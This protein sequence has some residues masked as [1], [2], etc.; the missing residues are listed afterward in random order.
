VEREKKGAYLQLFF[1]F[2]L[3]SVLF[4]SRRV[5]EY[6]LQ[7]YTPAPFLLPSLNIIP[8]RSL[9]VGAWCEYL[10]N[11][12]AD[13]LF[14]TIQYCIIKYCNIQYCTIQYYTIYVVMDQ[15]LFLKEGTL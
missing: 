13:I 6:F 14:C 15:T 3:H 9:S 8:P 1:S 2:Y 11:T 5:E 12:Q 10:L 4:L 7:I